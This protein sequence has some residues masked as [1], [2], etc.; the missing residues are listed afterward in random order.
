MPPQHITEQQTPVSGEDHSGAH[1]AT[2]LML[3]IILQQARKG[4]TISPS[5][6]RLWHFTSGFLDLDTI[7]ILGQLT[8]L[9]VAVVCL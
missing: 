2:R 4:L 5:V 7:D 9:R 3:Q 8:L 1:Q 6:G